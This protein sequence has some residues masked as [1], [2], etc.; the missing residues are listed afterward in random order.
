MQTLAPK[1][2]KLKGASRG[3]PQSSSYLLGLEVKFS[4]VF[5]FSECQQLVVCPLQPPSP[6]LF[7]PFSI[8]SSSYLKSKPTMC[9]IGCAGHNPP[10]AIK[11]FFSSP[12]CNT[13]GTVLSNIP[14]IRTVSFSSPEAFRPQK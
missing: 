6:P 10:T 8:D 12:S 3:S 11:H 14:C 9:D 7:F 13:L 4:S 1:Y 2:V 5:I